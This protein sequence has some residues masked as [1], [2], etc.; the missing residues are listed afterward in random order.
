MILAI[1]TDK[2]EAELHL[3]KYGKVIDSYIWQAHRELADTILS[4]INDFLTK[5]ETNLNHLKGLIVFTGSGSF[6]GLRIGTTVANG[7]SYGLSVP[8]V[9]AEG[10][11]WIEQGLDGLKNTKPNNFVIPKYSGEPNITKPKSSSA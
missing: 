2:P 1:R 3:L 9:A 8:I 6:T 5:N 10:D 7:L 4:K 11:S